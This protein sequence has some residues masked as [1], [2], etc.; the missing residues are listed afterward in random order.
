MLAALTTVAGYESILL[1]PV[2]TGK[3]MEG[4]IDLIVDKHQFRRDE[5]ILF[6]HSGGNVGPFGC[7]ARVEKFLTQADCGGAQCEGID[8][9]GG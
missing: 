5:D 9:H 4:L 1:D 3:P 7:V 8:A 2:Y 6:L